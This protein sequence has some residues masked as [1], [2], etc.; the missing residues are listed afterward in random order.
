M[1]YDTAQRAKIF[2]R[3]SQ[4][5]LLTNIFGFWRQSTIVPEYY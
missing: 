3:E 5:E 2:R 4:G 1:A